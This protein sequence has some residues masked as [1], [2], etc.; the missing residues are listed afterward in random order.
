MCQHAACSLGG[1]YTHRSPSASR[2][3]EME[4]GKVPFRED[5]KFCRELVFRFHVSFAECP[6]QG[7]DSQQVSSP[8]CKQQML[9]IIPSFARPTIGDTFLTR[10]SRCACWQRLQSLSPWISL[11]MLALFMVL[12]NALRTA[13]FDFFVQEPLAISEVHCFSMV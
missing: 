3:F 7:L 4:T 10:R 2:H 5:R 6:H 12:W 9:H 11:G 13:F 8:Y 1:I